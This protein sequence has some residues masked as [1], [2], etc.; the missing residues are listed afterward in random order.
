M[1]SRCVDARI[2]C[3]A[4]GCTSDAVRGCAA[5]LWPGLAEQEARQ[6]DENSELAGIA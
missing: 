4:V 3:V 6:P 2:A 1:H 5:Q